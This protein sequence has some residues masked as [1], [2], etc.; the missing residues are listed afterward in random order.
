MPR[1][2]ETFAV[3]LAGVLIAGAAQ[4]QDS[5][6]ADALERLAACRS[7]AD[8]PA[9]LACY[10]AAAAALDEAERSGEVVVLDRAQVEETRRGL[11]GF[12]MP[13]LDI[14]N[15]GGDRVEAEEIDNVSYVVAQARQADRNVWV[16]TME[17]GSVW[18]QID[19]RMWGRPRAG[20][21][22]VVRRAA[23]GSYMMNVGDAP[24]IR[25]RREQ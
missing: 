20:E 8:G 7:V 13:R 23:L 21:T 25:V 5:R 12:P 22:A 6:R 11:F 2:A 3:M 24:A 10:D 18:R 9:R 19:G 4:A 15:R 17:D 16:F 14:F 1:I